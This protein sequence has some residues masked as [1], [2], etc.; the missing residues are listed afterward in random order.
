MRGTLRASDIVAKARMPSVEHISKTTRG[1][2]EVQERTHRGYNLR[3][4]SKLVLEAIRE[5][6]HT[7]LAIARHVWDFSNVVEHVA[8]SEQED[9]D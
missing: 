2:S 4:Q 9:R 3:L 8:T 1:R 7:S 5:V 6:T